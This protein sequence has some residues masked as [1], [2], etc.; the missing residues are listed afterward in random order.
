M[1]YDY[2]LCKLGA[3]GREI[4][5]VSKRLRGLEA[6]VPNT[7]RLNETDKQIS[8]LNAAVQ[9]NAGQLADLST[10]VEKL[11]RDIFH[12]GLKEVNDVSEVRNHVHDLE[13]ALDDLSTALRKTTNFE[14]E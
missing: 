7:E 1:N 10:T 14:I 12:Q 4:E 11:E 6:S 3:L 13:Q 8:A 2:I 5:L 9:S